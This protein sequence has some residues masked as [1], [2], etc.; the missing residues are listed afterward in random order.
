VCSSDLASFFYS[1][2]ILTFSFFLTEPLLKMNLSPVYNQGLLLAPAIA[3]FSIEALEAITKSLSRR[4]VLLWCVFLVLAGHSVYAWES[5]QKANTWLA[6]GQNPPP[7][8]YLSLQQ[9]AQEH[10]TVNEVILSTKEVSFAVNA[11]TGRKLL[12]NRWQQQA[13]MYLDMY[14]RDRDAAIILYGTDDARRREL[15]RQYN[16]SYVYYDYYWIPSEF[17]FDQKGNFVDMYDPL[18]DRDTPEERA[19]LDQTGVAYSPMT[20][21]ID[22]SSRNPDVRQFPVLIIGPQ[23]YR[24]FNQPWKEGLDPYLTKVWNYTDAQGRESASLY[25][26]TA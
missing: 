11:F 3:L 15:L 2:L 5:E 14:A 8:Q 16:V 1:S 9:Y 24:S 20:Y 26:V 17:T 7:P 25:K 12:V 13:N 4:D 10:T 19:L 6:A 18:L 22:P 23:N 21:W